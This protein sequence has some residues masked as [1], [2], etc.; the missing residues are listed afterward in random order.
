MEEMTA[1]YQHRSQPAR[2]PFSSAGAVI[3]AMVLGQSRHSGLAMHKPL[4]TFLLLIH[5]PNDHGEGQ[6]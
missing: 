3:S 5:R 1:W 6:G 2:W 4:M